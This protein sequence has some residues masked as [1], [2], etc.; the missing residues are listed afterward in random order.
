MTF[1]KHSLVLT[2]AFTGLL[3]GTVARL[4]AAPS[5]SSNSTL[6]S[7]GQLLLAP[8]SNPI[9]FASGNARSDRRYGCRRT[10]R[11]W[12][13]PTKRTATRVGMPRFVRD[14]EI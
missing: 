14:F 1:S 2:A 9:S 5:S 7:Q 4:N 10:R 12:P 3:G 11:R 13:L 8:V 6:S